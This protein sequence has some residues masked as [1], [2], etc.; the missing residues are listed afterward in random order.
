MTL[1][2]LL[3]STLH[4]PKAYSVSSL[5][6]RRILAP[7]TSLATEHSGS[8]DKRNVV[9]NKCDDPEHFVFLNIP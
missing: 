6:S 8:R 7:T 9:E 4:R 1:V 5:T 3:F 2:A